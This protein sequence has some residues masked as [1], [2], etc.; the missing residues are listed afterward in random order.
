MI[1]YTTTVEVS[2]LSSKDVYDF[3]INCTDTQYQRW[4]LGT[5]LAFHTIKRTPTNIGNLVY[6]DEYVGDFHLKFYAVVKEVVPNRTI[7]WQMRKFG[8]LLPA[9]LNLNLSD[10]D[11]GITIIHSVSAGFHGIG[12]FLDVLLRLYLSSKFEQQ[13]AAH[14]HTEFHKLRALLR[15]PENPLGPFAC[16]VEQTRSHAAHERHLHQRRVRPGT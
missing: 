14:A 6:M 5:H 10:T 12:R 13:M 1:R 2:G 11:T 9:W 16:S 8:V 4:W 15:E 7:T 3:L